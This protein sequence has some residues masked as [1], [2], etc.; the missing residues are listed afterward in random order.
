MQDEESSEIWVEVDGIAVG[1][2]DDARAVIVEGPGG[3]HVHDHSLCGTLPGQVIFDRASFASWVRGCMPLVHRAVERG[4]LAGSFNVDDWSF[5]DDPSAFRRDWFGAINEPP[6][7]IDIGAL[8]L[9]IL[10]RRSRPK[11]PEVPELTL[12]MGPVASGKTTLRRSRLASHV[13]IDPAELYLMLTLGDTKVPANIGRLLQEAGR[14]VAL[15]A[16]RE[17]RH[18][19]L[20]VLPSRL[21]HPRLMDALQRVKALGYRMSILCCDV[22]LDVSLERNRKRADREISAVHTEIDAISWVRHALREIEQDL[23]ARRSN[24]RGAESGI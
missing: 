10:G 7:Q 24:E 8:E 14:A 5:P 13:P 23:A 19:V 11:G 21:A 20:E 12:V 17:R 16:L 4:R 9:D 3:R 6:A 15:A 2:V 18:V 1:L 22:P